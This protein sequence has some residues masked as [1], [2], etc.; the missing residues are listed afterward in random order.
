[1]TGA[2]SAETNRQSKGG[3]WGHC[4]NLVAWFIPLPTASKRRPYSGTDLRHQS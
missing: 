3:H 4:L 1:M 2:L